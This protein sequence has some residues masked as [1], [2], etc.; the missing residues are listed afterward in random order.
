MRVSGR[1]D[2]PPGSSQSTSNGSTEVVEDTL[3]AGP[4]ATVVHAGPY[5]QLS[6]AYAA[7]ET[8]MASHGRAARGAPWELYVT[9]PAEHPNPKDWRTE[10]YWPLETAPESHS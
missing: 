7:I 10:V 6:D 1:D 5:E 4:S 9:D 2:E 8:W 3:P